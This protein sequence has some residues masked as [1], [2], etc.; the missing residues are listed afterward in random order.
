MMG[1]S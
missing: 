1:K